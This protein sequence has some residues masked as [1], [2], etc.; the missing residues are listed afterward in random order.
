MAAVGIALDI[1]LV[2]ATIEEG[3]KYFWRVLD[4]APPFPIA[5]IVLFAG[6]QVA[7]VAT[8]SA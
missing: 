3:V 8:F 7:V 2:W 6:W 1:G 4:S 5:W